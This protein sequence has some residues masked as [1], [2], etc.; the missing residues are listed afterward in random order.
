MAP[1]A[2]ALP[3]EYQA[4]FFLNKKGTSSAPFFFRIKSARLTPGTTPSL[5][6]SNKKVSD[7]DKPNRRAPYQSL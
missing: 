6:N 1:N 3:E 2:A 5:I 4:S 7:L